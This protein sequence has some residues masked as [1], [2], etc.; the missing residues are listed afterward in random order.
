MSLILN[1]CVRLVAGT[2]SVVETGTGNKIGSYALTGN[3]DADL[4]LLKGYLFTRVTVAANIDL[5]GVW[6]GGYDPQPQ[7]Q[8]YFVAGLD[9]PNPENSEVIV[10]RGQVM[11]VAQ[12]AV[13]MEHFGMDNIPGI[14]CDSAEIASIA[15]DFDLPP[16]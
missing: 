1:P 12:V 16:T 4:A 10:A 15:L 11:T 7:P 9:V 6:V 8:L 13:V 2:L 3:H 14:I 5:D